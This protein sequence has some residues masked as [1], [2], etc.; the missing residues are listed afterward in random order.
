M[1][2]TTNVSEVNDLKKKLSPCF[3]KAL[4][5]LINV[6]FNLTKHYLNMTNKSK[7]MS[8]IHFLGIYIAKNPGVFTKRI[9]S[10]V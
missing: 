1:I 4:F 2:N 3:M 10:G 8:F 5:D 9:N 6:Q 7:N